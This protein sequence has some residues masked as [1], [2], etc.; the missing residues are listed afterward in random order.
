MSGSKKR[1]KQVIEEDQSN[2]YPMNEMTQLAESICENILEK[3]VSHS[4]SF[5]LYV[6]FL[7]T[8]LHSDV[9]QFKH[10]FQEGYRCLMQELEREPIS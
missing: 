10:R 1:V 2:Q 5:E 6:H 9:S 8:H 7:R 4:D 3:N